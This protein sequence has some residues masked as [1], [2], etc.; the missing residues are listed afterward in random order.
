MYTHL[1]HAEASQLISSSWR[2]I[3]S[4]GCL[5]PSVMKSIKSHLVLW[6]DLPRFMK[7]I[8][9]HLVFW[10]AYL[11]N[12]IGASFSYFLTSSQY[13]LWAALLQ[14][15]VRAQ[16]FL[17]YQKGKK[18][19]IHFTHRF[20]TSYHHQKKGTHRNFGEQVTNLLPLSSLI[21]L[22]AEDYW[23]LHESN[24]WVFSLNYSFL[25]LSIS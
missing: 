6:F 8:K 19:T 24:T 7:S 12:I 4:L 11:F 16:R 21:S 5:L 13:Q 25:N 17:H 14:E 10:F 22:V 9:S 23:L 2:K 15:D 3:V 18:Y 1:E 20:L